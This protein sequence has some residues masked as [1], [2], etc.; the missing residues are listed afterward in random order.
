VSWFLNYT[1]YL[2]V[3]NGRFDWGKYLSGISGPLVIGASNRG[4]LS[5][6]PIYIIGG[7][8]F[9]I[10]LA[11]IFGFQV[12]DLGLILS[13]IGLVLIGV[14]ETPKLN[15]HWVKYTGPLG[16]VPILLGLIL[17]MHII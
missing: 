5:T 4:D 6:A 8:I 11:F 15:L 10:G 9:F 14:R 3:A 12:A 2:Y 13:G 16:L 7:V 17:F 1:R